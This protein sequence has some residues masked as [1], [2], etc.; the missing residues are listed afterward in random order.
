LIVFPAWF[1]AITGRADLF[2]PIYRIKLDHNEVAGADE[3]V[4]Y[5]AAWSRWR[6]DRAPCPAGIKPGAV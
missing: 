1:P 4:A 5:E 3:M 2:R 6:P